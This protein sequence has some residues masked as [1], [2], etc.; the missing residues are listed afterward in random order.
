M[1]VY[2]GMDI[3]TAKASAAERSEIRHH[4]ID[5]VE[6]EEEY[7]A[8]RFQLEARRVVAAATSPLLLVGGSGLHFR[9][10]VDPLEFEP[11]DPAIRAEVETLGDDA[12]RAELGQ[13]DPD[14]ERVLDTRNRRRLVRAVEIL[15]LTSRTPSQRAASPGRAELDRYQPVVPVRVVGVDPGPGLAS[16]VDDRVA[17]MWDAGLVAEVAGLR[18]RMGRTAAGAVGYRQVLD[19]LE[20][21][22]GEDEAK[23]RVAIATTQLA[24]RQRTWFRRDPRIVWQPWSDDEVTLARSILEEWAL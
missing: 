8:A 21:V 3:G 4:M 15:R 18:G 12:L 5:L 10:V 11:T 22:I 2:R 24:K 7:S 20:G 14:V 16:R 17:R 1:Q 23:E 9:A 13:A 6:P 19:L